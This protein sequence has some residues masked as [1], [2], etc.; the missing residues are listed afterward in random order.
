MESKPCWTTTLETTFY[1]AKTSIY[2]AIKL[3]IAQGV[4]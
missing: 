1:E 4:P 2:D 3:E